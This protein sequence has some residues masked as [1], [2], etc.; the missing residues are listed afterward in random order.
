MGRRFAL[1]PTVLGP[2]DAGRQLPVEG[3]RWAAGYAVALA[4]RT[5]R[6]I[7]RLQEKAARQN[8]RLA[9][10]SM[11]TAV[12]LASPM[13]MEAFIDDLA[14]AWPRSSPDMTMPA[15]RHGRSGSP[16]VHIRPPAKSRE[17]DHLEES[18]DGRNDE[19]R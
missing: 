11:D 14:R 3:D 9:V 18:Q 5:T 10:G 15:R 7:A 8:K 17:A 6:E 16:S 12:H 2:L 13:A 4:S 19:V 1:D